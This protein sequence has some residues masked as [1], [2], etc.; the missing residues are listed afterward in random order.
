MPTQTALFDASQYN[1]VETEPIREIPV[2]VIEPDPNNPATYSEK[3]SELI[4]TD[5]NVEEDEVEKL[6]AKIGANGY[7]Y[8]APIVVRPIADNRFRLV[9]GHHTY[10]A[11]RALGKTVAPCIVR[12]MSEVDAQICLLTLQGR[13]VPDWY[14][15]KVVCNLLDQKVDPQT[16]AALTSIDTTTISSWR[17]SYRFINKIVAEMGDVYPSFQKAIKIKDGSSDRDKRFSIWEAREIGLL[18]EDDQIWFVKERLAR[19]A[20]PMPQA[21]QSKL[22]R[23]LK[24]TKKKIEPTRWKKWLKWEVIR[25]EIYKEFDSS[26]RGE[27]DLANSIPDLLEEAEQNYNDPRLPLYR[28]Y[29][30]AG[31]AAKKKTGLPKEEFLKELIRLSDQNG[32]WDSVDIQA[33]FKNVI[34]FYERVDQEYTLYLQ[35]QAAEK[36]SKDQQ[37]LSVAPAQPDAPPLTVNALTGQI[38]ISTPTSRVDIEKRKQIFEEFSPKGFNDSLLT[39]SQST[40]TTYSTILTNISSEGWVIDE[41]FENCDRL[42]DMLT[43]NGIAVIS[44]PSDLSFAIIDELENRVSSMQRLYLRDIGGSRINEY[45]KPIVTLTKIA[46]RPSPFL[47]PQECDHLLVFTRRSDTPIREYGLQ[48]AERGDIYKS[49]VTIFCDRQ[50]TFLDPFCTN[51]LI[52]YAAKTCGIRCDFLVSNSALFPRINAVAQSAS[53]PGSIFKDC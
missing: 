39:Y 8:S 20:D 5:I 24:D 6:I 52:P 9:R 29:Y 7:D 42:K 18:P 34:E 23:L 53:L 1:Q 40:N 19:L 13:K 33:A 10:V 45:S 47:R 37:I 44:C 50:H 48:V 3:Y 36:I 51:G 21:K 12:E 46:S 2:E 4:G 14:A 28:D 25:E 41:F 43:D 17:I 49:L 27:S 35:K 15:L 11:L 32:Y 22:I 30:E 26:S 38:E 16:I 31:R